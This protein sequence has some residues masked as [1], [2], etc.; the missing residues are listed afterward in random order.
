VLITK[1]KIQ[2]KNMFEEKNKETTTINILPVPNSTR[3]PLRKSSST[4]WIISGFM[5]VVLLLTILIRIYK[6]NQQSG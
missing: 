6:M 4:V 2:K 5:A 1:Q 3:P